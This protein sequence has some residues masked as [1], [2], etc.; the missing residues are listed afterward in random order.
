LLLSIK[1]LFG[2]DGQYYHIFYAFKRLLNGP[3][4]KN[5]I[6]LNKLCFKDEYYLS[7]KLCTDLY[8]KIEMDILKN[9]NFNICRKVRL[10]IGD[11]YQKNECS[12]F[13]DLF[14]VWSEN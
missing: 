10:R 5:I 11:I 8:N 2:Y 14:D 3:T 4:Y 7:Y 6:I 9:E 12:N 1:L 13:G